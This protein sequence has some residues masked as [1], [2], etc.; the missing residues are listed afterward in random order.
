M[1]VCHKRFFRSTDYPTQE[2]LVIDED[3]LADFIFAPCRPLNAV[4]IPQGGDADQWTYM[5][6][7]DAYGIMSL[8]TTYGIGFTATPPGVA[9][10]GDWSVTSGLYLWSAF[11]T[12]N[13]EIP[14]QTDPTCADLPG[15]TC[16]EMQACPAFAYLGCTDGAGFSFHSVLSHFTVMSPI[17]KRT[18]QGIHRR[19]SRKG[20]H[21]HLRVEARERPTANILAVYTRAILQGPTTSRRLEWETRR[22]EAPVKNA[23]QAISDGQELKHSNRHRWLETLR[24]F[25]EH[26]EALHSEFLDIETRSL[27]TAANRLLLRTGRVYS[28]PQTFYMTESNHFT[29]NL[30]SVR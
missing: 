28:H 4:I 22:E 8:T 21:I 3:T 29:V 25:S 9:T 23:L 13:Y 12:V 18:L 16:T 10:L 17:D 15:I 30:E 27:D 19:R 7:G 2:C 1:A 5:Q 24:A 14:W 26:F 11:T 6:V 20:P